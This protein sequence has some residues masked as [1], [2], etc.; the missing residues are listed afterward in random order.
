MEMQVIRVLLPIGIKAPLA[1]DAARER[2]RA[3]ARERIDEALRARTRG[4]DELV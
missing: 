2:N 4:L 1:R 3:A